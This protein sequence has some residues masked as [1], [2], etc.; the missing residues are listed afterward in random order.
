MSHLMIW[1]ITFIN[2]LLWSKHI[3]CF[4]IM[5]SVWNLLYF[6]VNHLEYLK[7]K[8][9]VWG[10]GGEFKIILKIIFISFEINENI[11]LEES[12]NWRAIYVHLKWLVVM[13]F[14]LVDSRHSLGIV[15]TSNGLNTER[16][17]PVTHPPPDFPVTIP[18]R[19]E[20]KN[21]QKTWKFRKISINV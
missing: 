4:P 6:C 19:V 13:K 21:I 5:R 9:G 15:P 14:F 17:S 11:L 2:H 18:F 8:S 20:Q 12:G 16:N 10:E 7:K 1:K 3:F